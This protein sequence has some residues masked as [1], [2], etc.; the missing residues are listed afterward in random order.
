VILPKGT[1]RESL[2]QK[3]PADLD[4]RHL[5]TTPL[6]QFGTMGLTDHVVERESWRLEVTGRVRNPFTLT[7]ERLLAFPPVEKRVLLICP[8]F[9]ANHGEWKGVSIQALLKIAEPEIGVT[10]VTVRGPAG[11]FEKTQRYPIEH[12]LNDR[13]FLAYE[14]NGRPLPVK[15]GAPLRVVADGYYGFDWIKYVRTLTV[16]SIPKS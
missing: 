13:V 15:H 1:K 4:A 8:G 5:E 11:R 6:K 2:I 12:I 3:N 9:F 16:E 14:V 10:H 7:Y